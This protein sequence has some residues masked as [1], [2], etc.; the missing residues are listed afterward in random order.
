MTAFDQQ[1]IKG[2]NVILRALLRRI[3][4]EKFY[5]V[6]IRFVAF[7]ESITDTQFFRH[8]AQPVIVGTAFKFRL[9]GFFG[10][11]QIIAVTPGAADIPAFQKTGFRQQQVSIFRTRG[12]IKVTADDKF[13]FRFILQ[14]A[15]GMKNISVLVG[16]VVTRHRE[17]H[18]DFGAE[19]V[20]IF[21]S[22]L[23]GHQGFVFARLHPIG[24]V[25]FG[26][27]RV[28]K[29]L[30]SG[31]GF[32]QF[33]IQRHAVT[34]SPAA[35]HTDITGNR[36]QQ[37]GPAR[38]ALTADMTLRPPALHQHRRF[39]CGIFTRQLT[40]SV[41]RDFGDF[42]C[43]FRG[44][45]HAVFLTGQIRHQRFIIRH[46]FRHLIFTETQGVFI[47]KC[48]IVQIFC[49]DDIHHRIHHGVVG[50]RQQ[51]DPLI[52]QRRSGIGIARINDNKFGAV[53]FHFLEIVVTVPENRFVRVMPPQDH[54]RRIFQGIE[55]AA[56]GR[57]AIGIGR[58]RHGVAVTDGMII[59]Q[60]AAGQVKQA[61][62]HICAGKNPAGHPGTQA[63]KPRCRAVFV[64]D[65]LPFGGNQA[66]R[67]FPA[68]TLKT[69]FTALTDPLHRVF[70]AIRMINKFPV[71]ASAHT[72]PHDRHLF[73]EFRIRPGRDT[74]SF[75]VFDMSADITFPA[76]VKTAAGR[77]NVHAVIRLMNRN[78][79]RIGRY[80]CNTFGCQKR[81]CR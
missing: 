4:N 8:F 25:D 77:Y 3:I 66:G 57:C 72:G 5:P 39:G 76:A 69:S 51:R 61:A 62:Q 71:A 6:A 54:Q 29:Q 47:N 14:H 20:C 37:R 36:C 74:D 64:T 38:T 33:R 45:D 80:G 52:R 17:H 49:H 79:C 16:H 73:I 41:R 22:V 67:F 68:D 53:L 58:G 31:D 26:F 24:D 75:S 30:R 48:L 1:F 13:D 35:A 81:H 11:D 21:Q 9:N 10:Q 2:W 65:A 7:G 15:G 59:F 44:F 40:D 60:K 55:R 50:G 23:R 56:A 63:D 46:A 43:P 34:R 12:E 19:F 32:T 42:F 27:D 78:M 18:F 70:Q 28:I